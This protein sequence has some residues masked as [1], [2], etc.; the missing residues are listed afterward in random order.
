MFS[1]GYKYCNE[2]IKNSKRQGGLHC[3]WQASFAYHGI[4]EDVL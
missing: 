4:K 2:I 3:I 1:S